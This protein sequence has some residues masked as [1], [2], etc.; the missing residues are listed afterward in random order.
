MCSHYGQPLFC[1]YFVLCFYTYFHD[2]PKKAAHT[3]LYLQYFFFMRLRRMVMGITQIGANYQTVV[4]VCFIRR[5]INERQEDVLHEYYTKSTKTNDS[6]KT[7]IG[8]EYGSFSLYILLFGIFVLSLSILIHCTIHILYWHWRRVGLVDFL[9][10]LPPLSKVMALTHFLYQFLSFVLFFLSLSLCFNSCLLPF[11]LWP[12]ASISPS[13][14]FRSFCLVA[15]LVHFPRPFRIFLIRKT[16]TF[17]CFAWF[18]FPCITS[19]EHWHRQSPISVHN[20]PTNR[21]NHSHVL[22]VRCTLFIFIRWAFN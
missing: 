18:I 2:Q 19:I 13:P 9:L 3:T 4:C 17:L 15:R 21:P 1:W 12:L 5:F 7:S 14:I 16:V 10:F 6:N 22:A 20:R 11:S 8:S